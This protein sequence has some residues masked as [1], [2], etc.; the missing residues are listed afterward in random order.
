[1]NGWIRNLRD[2][3]VEAVF[4]GPANGVDRLVAWAHRGPAGAAVDGVSVRAES[5]EGLAGFVVA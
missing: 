1:V 2:G 4:E 3:R 5:P